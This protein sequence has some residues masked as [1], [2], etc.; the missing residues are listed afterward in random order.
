MT[1]DQR[2]LETC[3]A[4]EAVDAWNAAHPVGVP[5]RYWTGLRSG[6]GFL[7]RTRAPASV[8]GGH[9]AVVWVVGESACIAL[10]HVKSMEAYR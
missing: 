5:V 8:L 10:T 1:S 9:T 4:Q 6:S 7:S 3:E 2:Q